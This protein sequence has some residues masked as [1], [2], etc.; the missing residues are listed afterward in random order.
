MSEIVDG[1]HQRRKELSDASVH[2]GKDVAATLTGGGWTHRNLGFKYDAFKGHA[3]NANATA[4]CRRFRMQI[5][6]GA[7]INKFSEE[8]AMRLADAWRHKMQA[9]L[10]ASEASASDARA[11]EAPII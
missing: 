6:F 1:L 4:W 8:V 3:T 9:Y 2:K 7:P 5:A 10:D 11:D